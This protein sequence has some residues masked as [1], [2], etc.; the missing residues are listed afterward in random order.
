MA[1]VKIEPSGEIIVYTGISPHGQGTE[2]SFAQIV[3]VELGVS[4]A[5][6][7][8][9]HGDTAML[10]EGGGTAAS[11]GT[12][13]GASALYMAVQETRQKLSRIAS[14]LMECPAEDIAFQDGHVINRR[15]PQKTLSFSEVA[16]AAYNEELLPLGVEVG[17]DVSSTYT[18]PNN[19]FSFAAH[20]AVVEVDRDTGDVKIVKYVAVHDCGPVINRVL[21]DGQMHGGIVQGIGQALTEGM[22]YDSN[23]QPLT[24]SLM[25][26]A[27]P[28]AEEMP[29][30][31][32]DHVE[33]PSPL[34][35]MGVKGVGEL[36]TVAAPVAVANAVL[37]ALSGSGV[38]HI[39]APL[40]PEKIWNA[41]HGGAGIATSNMGDG[42]AS[43]H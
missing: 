40:T 5:E 17:L 7:Q 2:T 38:R 33:T 39:D 16:S 25:D 35:P 10:P 23:G 41:L 12:V 19:P 31:V 32:L 8:V 29:D 36:P 20:V 26:Y 28:V 30:M 13:V 21:L 24:G 34:T 15:D 9:L 14:H 27:L 3:A 43:I 42:R 22:V 4:P 18:L 1:E 37:D 11:R 6:V